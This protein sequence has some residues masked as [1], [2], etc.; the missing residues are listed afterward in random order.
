MQCEVTGA[1]TKE[2]AM[3]MS[4]SV[5]GSLLVKAAVHGHDPNWGR[6][7]AAV[8][9]AQVLPAPSSSLPP[10]LPPCRPHRLSHCVSPNWG[11]RRIAYL[12]PD[13]ELSL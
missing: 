2:D 1:A 11:D 12:T 8:G 9:Y 10:C 7:A 5:V 13:L 6:I 3:A 4:K